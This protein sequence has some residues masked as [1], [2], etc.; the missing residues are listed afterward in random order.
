M[1][2]ENV[3]NSILGKRSEA[4]DINLNLPRNLIHDSVH[5]G[6]A[7]DGFYY[8]GTQCTIAVGNCT[9]DYFILTND[10]HISIAAVRELGESKIV[11]D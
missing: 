3:V 5:L 10:T 11:Y 1:A 8:S 6:Q 7:A 9:S 2:L 4:K